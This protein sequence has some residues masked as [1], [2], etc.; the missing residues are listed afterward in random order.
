MIKRAPPRSHSA[1][2]QLPP[3]SAVDTVFMSETLVMSANEITRDALPRSRPS[4]VRIDRGDVTQG[5]AA[6]DATESGA[7]AIPGL[8]PLPQRVGAFF[9][10]SYR[11]AGFFVLI[12]ILVG[13]STYV[14]SHLFFLANRGWVAP[15]VLTAADPRVL[16]FAARF[17][18]ESSRHDALL[19][20]RAALELRRRDAERSV[21]IESA[22]QAAYVASMRAD[23][24]DRTADLSRARGMLHASSAAR[25]SISTAGEAF[26]GSS[27]GRLKKE[28][29]A[30][31]I[32]KDRM[33]NGNLQLAQL[34]G[35]RLSLE[36]TSLELQGRVAA[37]TRAVS[38]L[39]AAAS[40]GKG[41]SS[42]EILRIRAEYDRSVAAGA[43]AADEV[44]AATKSVAML[45]TTIRAEEAILETMRRSPYH[46]LPGGR[47]VLAFVPYEN[48]G[49]ATEGAPVY[50][51]RVGIV[52]CRKVGSLARP[53]EGEV[54]QK[55]PLLHQDLRGIFVRMN[56]DEWAAAESAVLHVGRRP[57]FL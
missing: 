46:E 54:V 27:E 21:E 30:G 32:D 39:D 2:R 22:F 25:R 17:V 53:A 38:S 29:D 31:I 57:L 15:S 11:L 45:D 41:V 35:T 4:L 40:G 42:Y 33:L 36:T 37:L 44:A 19:V 13:L 9:V 28:L 12:A 6:T 26:R 49:A 52:W 51:C 14:G 5:R 56:V 55:H 3:E 47:G 48:A 20:Q 8:A 10:K 43:K 50:A 7:R 34:A 16:G 18:E 24:A 23:L 1:A